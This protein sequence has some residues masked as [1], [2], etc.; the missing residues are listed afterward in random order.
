MMNNTSVCFFA[1]VALLLAKARMQR[2]GHTHYH[3]KEENDMFQSLFR[4]FTLVLDR[5]VVRMLFHM[6]GH[7]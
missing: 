7:S 3:N 2:F 6:S 1:C 4:A 5:L